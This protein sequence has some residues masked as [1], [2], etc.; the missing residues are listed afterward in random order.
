[1]FIKGRVSLNVY[2]FEY[3]KQKEEVVK[4]LVDLLCGEDNEGEKV[5]NQTKASNYGK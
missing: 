1:M 3:G 2:H 4:C 5:A